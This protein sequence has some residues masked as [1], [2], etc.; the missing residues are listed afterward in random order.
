[1]PLLRTYVLAVGTRYVRQR[2][3]AFA[4]L[5]PRRHHRR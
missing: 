3:W 4:W 1:V 2:E 5:E